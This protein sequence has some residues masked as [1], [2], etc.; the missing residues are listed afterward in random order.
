[1]GL[2]QGSNQLQ[3]RLQADASWQHSLFYFA[4]LVFVNKIFIEDL[5]LEIF[6]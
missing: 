2:Q 3:E 4:N 1:M 5:L 6:V